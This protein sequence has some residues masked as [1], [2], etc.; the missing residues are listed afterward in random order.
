MNIQGPGQKPLQPLHPQTPSQPAPTAPAKTQPK[1]APDPFQD[2]RETQPLPGKKPTISDLFGDD[3]KP[4]PHRT[5]LAK[6][7][8]GGDS[9]LGFP[10]KPPGGISAQTQAT[11]ETG[12]PGVKPGHGTKMMGEDGSPT[13]PPGGGIHAQTQATHETG[14]PG[15][16][17]GH[18]T[19]M[20]GEDGTPGKLPID[21]GT[22]TKAPGEEGGDLKPSPGSGT[23][24]I[25]EDGTPVPKDRV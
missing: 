12:E 19:K 20:V 3:M 17:P 14:E 18:G 5:T 10:G 13:K 4:P 11:H 2:Q 23:K 9:P 1:P 24:M 6:G 15:I 21:P 16:K 7:E 8:E 25:G 22:T